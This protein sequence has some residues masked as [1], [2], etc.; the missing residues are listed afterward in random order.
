M[1]EKAN[2]N[3]II[4]NK[5]MLQLIPSL[6]IERI[7]EVFTYGARKYSGWN[8]AKGIEYSRLYGALQRHMNAWYRG[9]N[10]DPETGKSHLAHAGC[11]LM[12]LLEL[13]E[14]RPDLDDRPQ[15]YK[16]KINK[17]E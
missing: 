4:D 2:K 11:C 12:M 7:G 1:E 3:D 13:E 5:N 9:E 17:D 15:H 16:S 10:K 6:A 8:W 14:L